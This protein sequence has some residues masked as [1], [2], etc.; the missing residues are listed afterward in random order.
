LKHNEVVPEKVKARF[1]EPMLLVKTDKLPEGHE[2]LYTPNYRSNQTRK[3]V[4]EDR[5]RFAVVECLSGI[6]FEASAQDALLVK[7]RFIAAHRSPVTAQRLQ[8]HLDV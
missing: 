7:L 6:K 2:W 4:P 1:L 5:H 3:F 8:I